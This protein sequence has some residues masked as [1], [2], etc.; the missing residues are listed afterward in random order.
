MDAQVLEDR[1][2]CQND[3]NTLGPC[4]NFIKIEYKCYITVVLML[5]ISV[6]VCNPS[7]GEVETAEPW[8]F[9]VS[10]SC[11]TERPRQGRALTPK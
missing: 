4:I 8:C 2:W 5:D 7:V 3:Q 9:L 6:S 11:Q 10:P 1:S